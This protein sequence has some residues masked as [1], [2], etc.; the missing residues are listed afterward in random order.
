M[1]LLKAQLK[2][3]H[4]CQNEHVKGRLSKMPLP[5]PAPQILRWARCKTWLSHSIC[6]CARVHFTLF[7]ALEP[8]HQNSGE[9][10]PLA[11]T[12]LVVWLKLTHYPVY[13][14]HLRHIAESTLKLNDTVVAIQTTEKYVVNKHLNANDLNALRTEKVHLSYYNDTKKSNLAK[15]EFEWNRPKWSQ[16]TV[17]TAVWKERTQ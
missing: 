14:L 7:T 6:A 8:W 13:F 3:V 1:L 4:F 15:Y 9:V 17:R 12:F 5:R 10:E 2:T 11:S 16:H